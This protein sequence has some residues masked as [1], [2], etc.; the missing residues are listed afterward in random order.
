MKEELRPISAL[1]QARLAE[2]AP[3][4]QVVI[5]PRQVGKTT[6]VKAVLKHRGVYESAD[7]PV[8]LT[9]EVIG[10][11]WQ[12]ALKTPDKILVIDE[13]QKIREWSEAIKQFWDAKPRA[14]KVVLTGSSALQVEKGLRETLAGRFELI[15]VEHWNFQEAQRIFGLS[16]PDY[17]SFGCYPG[18][19]TFLNNVNRWADYVRDS[20]V[21]PALGRDL[22]QLHPIDNPALLR[23]IFGVAVDMPAQLISLQKMQGQLQDRGTLPTIQHYMDLLGEAFLVTAIQKYSPVTIRT[24]RSTPKLIVHDNGLIHAFERPVTEKLSAEKLGRYFENAVGARLVE[25]G[26]ETYYWKDRDYEVDFVVLGPNGEKW[27][28]EVKSA[29]TSAKELVGV[30]RFCTLYPEFEPVLVSLTGQGVDGFRKISA[31]DVLS[32]HRQYK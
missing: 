2:K 18:S 28:V 26:W 21:E 7:S 31:E 11:W 3:L 32:L 22:L 8:P 23:Q 1:L 20:I 29:K 25:A 12:R 24:R 17:I 4:I 27:A 16:L 30:T 6:L 15:R 13:V 5:G 10:N 14:L 19:M 9:H